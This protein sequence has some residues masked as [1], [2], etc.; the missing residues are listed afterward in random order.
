MLCHESAPMRYPFGTGSVVF[1]S[2]V[3]CGRDYSLVSENRLRWQ[4]LHFFLYPAGAPHD[5]KPVVKQGK[6]QMS[7]STDKNPTVCRLFVFLIH[8]DHY[9]VMGKLAK[10]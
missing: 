6:G 3:C 8:R 2:V 7:V 1:I 10:T 5:Q 9:R 4:Y